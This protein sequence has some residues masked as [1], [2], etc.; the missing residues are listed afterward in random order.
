MSLSKIRLYYLILIA[1]LAGYV[2]LYISNTWAG[3]GNNPIEVCLIKHVT[4]MPCP[5]CGTTRSVMSL[6]H[7]NFIEALSINPL[8]YVIAFI[9]TI[10]PVWIIMDVVLQK[11]TL[12]KVYQ[13]MEALFK[14]PIVFVLFSLSIIINWAWNILKGL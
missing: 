11:D 2:W 14:R 8:G 3:Y 7:G 13:R 5:S 12:F 4:N 10:G 6:S 1:C 9:M